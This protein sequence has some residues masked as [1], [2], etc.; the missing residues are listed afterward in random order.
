MAKNSGPKLATSASWLRKILVCLCAGGIIGVTEAGAQAFEVKV[1][2][3]DFCEA[4]ADSLERAVEECEK[5]LELIGQ[6]YDT[7]LELTSQLYT[8]SIESI[9]Q[10]YR[11]TDSIT[12]QYTQQLMAVLTR[13]LEAE[14]RRADSLENLIRYSGKE[15]KNLGQ[16]KIKIG[17]LMKFMSNHDELM[18]AFALLYE[19]IFYGNGTITQ[20][21]YFKLSECCIEAIYDIETE[22]SNV[23]NFLNSGGRRPIGKKCRR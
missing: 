2:Q 19:C 15:W 23:E 4:R 8:A 18:A 5:A 22:Y 1:G 9:T 3:L 12:S 20:D 10:L 14:K 21:E 6:V 17:D 7:T 16:G 11:A 13:Q